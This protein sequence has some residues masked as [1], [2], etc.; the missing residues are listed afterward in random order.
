MRGP[1]RLN[2]VLATS[3]AFGDFDLEPQI[4]A[5]PDIVDIIIGKLKDVNGKD[6]FVLDSMWD[7]DS[8]IG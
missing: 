2:G 8:G 1:P 3:R 4:I 5:T 7:E 6:T